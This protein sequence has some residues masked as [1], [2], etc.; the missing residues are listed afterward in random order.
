MRGQDHKAPSP[1][2][3][4]QVWSGR[5]LLTGGV[6]DWA[7]EVAAVHFAALPIS[8]AEISPSK[9]KIEW[10]R[11][12]AIIFAMISDRNSQRLSKSAKRRIWKLQVMKCLSSELGMS[13]AD[14]RRIL[15]KRN[16]DELLDE[17]Y[18]ACATDLEAGAK[19]VREKLHSKYGV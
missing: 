4:P 3:R 2:G 7:P 14:I 6:V 1:P 12:S 11:S 13:I 5:Y 8:V 17:A 19:A 18:G 10:S 9:G 15:G 16:F